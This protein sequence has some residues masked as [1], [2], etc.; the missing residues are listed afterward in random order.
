MPNTTPVA[1]S[2]FLGRDASFT[3][4]NGID[5]KDVKSVQLSRDTAAEVD[6]TTRGSGDQKEMAF[7]RSETSIEVTC[8]DHSCVQGATGT[9]TMTL[10]GNGAPARPT[11][12]FQV[13]SISESE[14][15]DNAVEFTISLKRTVS[16]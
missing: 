16:A 6:V 2:Y 13:M 8:L 15:L 5:N 7:V 12:V 1:H 3:F 14:D 11:G 10:E 4:S 9:I